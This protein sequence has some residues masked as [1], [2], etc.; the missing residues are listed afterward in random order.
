[1]EGPKNGFTLWAALIRPASVGALTL[2]SAAPD[3]P[4]LIDPAYLAKEADVDA[5]EW[6]FNQMREIEKAGALGEWLGE[7]LYPGPDETSRA[8]IRAYIRQTATTYF[9]QVGTCR[10]GVDE[11]AVVDPGLRVHGIDGLR[12]ADAVGDAGDLV[13]QH[14]RSHDDDRRASRRPRH[15]RFVGSD[16]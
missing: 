12:V 5:L 9:H 3:H 7:E 11:L 10:M 1:M 16:P 2:A 13:R 6:S 8:D 14:P 15:R 4:P